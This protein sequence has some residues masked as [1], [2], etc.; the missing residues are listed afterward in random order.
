MKN[1]ETARDFLLEESMINHL[2][3]EEFPLAAL[4]IEDALIEF[5]KYHVQEALICAS[6]NVHLKNED[7]N[8]SA[9]T[10]VYDDWDK[11]KIIIDKESITN[12]YPLKNIT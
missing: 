5:A 2:L 8:E 1:L 4:H 3:L 7:T 11:S 10:F 6:Q 12:S 9:G